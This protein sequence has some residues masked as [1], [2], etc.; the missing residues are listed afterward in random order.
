MTG[1]TTEL[2]G[3]HRVAASTTVDEAAAVLGE[4]FL[5]VQVSPTEGSSSLRM[6]LNALTV[7]RIT[8]GWMCFREAVRLCTA[9]PVNY[10]L[11]IPVRSQSTMRADRGT[12]FRGTEQTAGVFMPGRSVEL[13]CSDWFAQVAVMIPHRDLQTE[14]ELLLDAPAPTPLEFDAEFDLTTGGGRAVSQ[15]VRLVDEGSRGT[16]GLLAH[17]LAVRSLEQVFLHSLLLGQPHNHSA[18]LAVPRGAAGARSVAQAVELLRQDPARPWTVG[19]LAAAV[20]TS[21]RSLQESF[22]R[23]LDTTPTGYLRRLRLERAR[24]DLLTAAPG[25]VTV[26]EVAARWGFLHVSRFAGAYAERFGEL[27][28]ATLRRGGP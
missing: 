7:G 8:F 10:H 19:E 2:F 13:D 28:S 24:E 6:Q 25:A 23:T 20:S 26:S 22:R 14:L 3:L 16:T 12:R 11:D 27:P 15:A 9:E 1:A 5:P 21:V 4:V 17:P 18:A